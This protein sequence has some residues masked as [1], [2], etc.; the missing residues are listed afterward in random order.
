M[1]LH[2]P[3]APPEHLAGYQPWLQPDPDHGGEHAD[4]GGRGLPDRPVA[5]L[6]DPRL[7]AGV[8]EIT[9]LVGA[10]LDDGA[11]AAE[12]MP[13][14]RD[15][16][17]HWLERQVRAGQLPAT[18][19][20]QF[21]ELARAVH[22]Q[23]YGL[24]PLTAYLRDPQV[25]NVDINGCDQVWISYA[26]GERVA[27]PPVAASD[28]ALIAMVRTWATRG[29]QTRTRLLRRGAAGERRALRRRPVDRDDVR[30]AAAVR[31][32]APARPAGCDA[33]Q[34]YTPWHD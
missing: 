17:R 12:V 2:W 3:P 29:G 33:G 11:S 1:T 23:R 19:G 9:A 26:S 4:N 13:V 21:E 10:G 25:E 22:D 7:V 20:G 15:T 31:L 8:A 16:A 30:H 24:G 34:A 6:S 32:A 5:G 28:D 27:G 18:V 14:I